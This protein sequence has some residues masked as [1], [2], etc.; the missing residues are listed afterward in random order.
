MRQGS[1]GRGN[2]GSAVLPP[3]W[4]G[5]YREY[6][7][8]GNPNRHIGASVRRRW[9]LLLAQKRRLES[10]RFLWAGQVKPHR[11]GARRGQGLPEQVSQEA[12]RRYRRR[13]THTR[14]RAQ[15][16]ADRSER[17]GRVGQRRGIG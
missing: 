14:W 16:A 13:V 15:A 8:L 9:R 17:K 10:R 11:P 5:E 6:Y 3:A 1:N 12:V 7:R 4:R 2:G